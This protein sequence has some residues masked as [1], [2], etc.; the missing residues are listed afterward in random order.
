[1]V[2]KLTISD[3]E[4]STDNESIIEE[5]PKE[6]KKVVKPKKVLSEKQLETLAKG[7]ENRKLKIEESKLNKK[8]EASKLL[9]QEEHKNR[10]KEVK[11]E[12]KVEAESESDEEEVVIIEKKRKPKKK[13]KK[14]II[15][16]SESDEDEEQEIVVPE[17]KM[18]SQRNKKT[19][20]VH[21]EVKEL[22][23]PS[24]DEKATKKINYK[25]YFV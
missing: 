9:L 8:I 4:G 1:M 24:F 13:V 12:V 15:Q 20:V 3:D 14:I 23:D 11:K 25:N 17:K 22:P 21:D 2:K 7:R 6:I 18:K 10:K 19:I 5:V 16:E